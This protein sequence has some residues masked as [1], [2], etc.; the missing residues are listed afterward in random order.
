M[1]LSANNDMANAMMEAYSLM[2]LHMVKDETE[3]DVQDAWGHYQQRDTHVD[4][5]IRLV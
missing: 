4:S 3:R 1:L 5:V 2:V